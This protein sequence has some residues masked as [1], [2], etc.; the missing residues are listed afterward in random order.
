[1]QKRD[2]FTSSIGVTL[3]TLGSAVGLG[4]IWKFPY[5]TGANGG[6]SFLVV[7]I[8]CT[9]LVGLP[10][11]MAEI[12]IGRHVKANAV[13]SYK[14]LSPKGQPW[15]LIGVS[16]VV[17]AFAIM[18]FYSGVAGW[19]FAYV[20][21]SIVALFT[22]T[23]ATDSVA[24]FNNLV[25]DPIQPIIWQYIVLVSVGLIIMMGVAKGIEGTVKKLM[26]VLFFLLIALGIRS[27][28][29]PGASKGLEF[30]FSPDFSKID[31]TVILMALGLAFFKLSIGMGTMTTYGSYYRND[32]NVPTTTLRVMLADLLVSMLAGI[33]IFPAVFAF[34][35]EPAAGP[36]LL[37]LTIPEVFKSMPMGGVFQVLFFVL[38]AV[39]SIGAMLSLI[40][41]P[42]A[43]ATE[44]LG[45][46]RKSVTVITVILLMIFGAPAA[47]A[48][49][50]TK[51]WQLFGL[52]PFDFY[53]YLSSN[54]LLPIG[55]LAICLFAA[56]VWGGKAFKKAM[57]ND[58]A[59][60]NGGIAN[61]VVLLLKFVTPLL[62]LVILLQGLGLI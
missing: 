29:L 44:T 9:F 45:W 62:I 14:R 61:I 36:S 23:Q 21:K 46:S 13:E 42:V 4:N 40:E 50:V 28:T 37:F 48:T 49:S 30:L 22:G 35:M 15:F 25:N 55:G 3:A 26:P 2:G 41:V 18:A 52:N 34:G 20:F 12:L 39:A 6:A 17:A 31:S 58:G 54:L 47:L 43:F 16:G 19:V 38:T 7:Y 8:A 51:D 56:W 33:A 57:S 11:M 5:M 10:I 60:H 32:Q 59:L 53:D 24:M 1:M 27:M